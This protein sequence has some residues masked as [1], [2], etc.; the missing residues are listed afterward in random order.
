L[1]IKGETSLWQPAYSLLDRFG[2][3][4]L[5]TVSVHPFGIPR[6]STMDRHVTPCG[7]NTPFNLQLE[8]GHISLRRA[9]EQCDVTAATRWR[10]KI[11]GIRAYSCLC[12]QAFRK[13]HRTEAV[14]TTYRTIPLA[15]RVLLAGTFPTVSLS[16]VRCV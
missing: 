9:T 14:F 4:N 8:R 3:P 11:I 15:L 13:H 2:G 12:P 5:Q 1:Q 7:R 16:R 10:T 6:I